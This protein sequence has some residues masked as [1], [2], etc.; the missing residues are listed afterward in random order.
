M[1][2]KQKIKPWWQSKSYWGAILLALGAIGGYLSGNL[3]AV[4]SFE[5]VAA[6]LGI[7]GLRHALK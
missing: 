6:A 7:F 4:E 3:N 5:A 1:A 2:K